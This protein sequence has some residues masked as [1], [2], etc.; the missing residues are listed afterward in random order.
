[1]KIRPALRVQ[2]TDAGHCPSTALKSTADGQ[3]PVVYAAPPA[4]Q[5][6]AN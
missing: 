2:A 3:G 5:A 4:L 1:M 6:S